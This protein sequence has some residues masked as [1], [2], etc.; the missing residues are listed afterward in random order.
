MKQWWIG[1]SGFFYKSWRERFYPSNI[2]A[3]AWFE[4]YCE[5]FNA[6]EINATH[7]RFPRANELARWYVRCPPVFRFTV[8]APRLI[9]HF[10]KFNNVR[11]ETNDFYKAIGDGLGDKLGAA[12]FQIH[13]ALTYS[14]DH[15]N[16]ILDVLDPGF[17]NVVEFRDDSWWHPVVIRKLRDHGV[18]FCGISYPN[19]PDYP[20]KTSAVVYHRFHGVPRLYRSSYNKPKLYPVVETIRGFRQVSDAYCFFNNDIDAAAVRDAKRLREIIG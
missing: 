4:Y 7:Y 2:P 15:L 8:K 20:C 12:L 14:D 5:A 1:C 6:L 3:R 19:L 18:S 13:P 17:R 9:T 10:K 16:R 11:R